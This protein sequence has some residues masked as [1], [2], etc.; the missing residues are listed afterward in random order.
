MFGIVTAKIVVWVLSGKRVCGTLDSVSG[1]KRARAR[2]ESAGG[3]VPAK[4]ATTEVA[5]ARRMVE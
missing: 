5:R 4:I 2:A 3:I 1:H